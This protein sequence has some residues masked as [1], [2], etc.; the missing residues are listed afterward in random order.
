MDSVLAF[1]Q[2]SQAWIWESD[3]RALTEETESMYGTQNSITGLAGDIVAT[4]NLNWL[5]QKP[6]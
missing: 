2:E 3:I 5:Q 4:Y 6:L 1:A